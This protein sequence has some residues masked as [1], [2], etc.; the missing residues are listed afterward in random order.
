MRREPCAVS[1][2]TLRNMP[3]VRARVREGIAEV[4]GQMDVR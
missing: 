4:V 1:T 3:L 2:G